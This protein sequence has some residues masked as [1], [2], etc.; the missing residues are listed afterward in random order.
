L[1]GE[2]KY[3]EHPM[4]KRS[5][6]GEFAEMFEK[7]VDQP[8][9]KYSSKRRD[10][11]TYNQ[12]ND[13]VEKIHFKVSLMNCNIWDTHTDDFVRTVYEEAQRN[14]NDMGRK[15]LLSVN[16]MFNINEGLVYSEMKKRY[17]KNPLPLSVLTLND[18]GRWAVSQI[19]GHLLP[20]AIESKH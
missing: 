9:K 3:L 18:N 10:L 7:D 6:H 14:N 13:D 5:Q 4:V 15:S 12:D 17:G 1:Y 16:E 2:G 8:F 11:Y 20:H 19:L